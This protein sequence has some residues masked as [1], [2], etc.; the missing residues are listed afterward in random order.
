MAHI[1]CFS[2]FVFSNSLQ[3]VLEYSNKTST[4]VYKQF[5]LDNRKIME[6]KKT[7][8]PL[9]NK[10]LQKFR[11]KELRKLFTRPKPSLVSQV[12]KNL[13]LDGIHDMFKLGPFKQADTHHA[14]ETKNATT[15]CPINCKCKN[16]VKKNV[17]AFI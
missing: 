16:A 1:N 10:D 13:I 8:E 12:V 2:D 9:S 4:P 6:K 14:D 15:S 7:V 17:K 5:I 3:E 11:L